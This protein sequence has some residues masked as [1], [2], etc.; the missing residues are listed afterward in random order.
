MTNSSETDLNDSSADNIKHNQS[1]NSQKDKIRINQFTCCEWQ[2]STCKSS[3][4]GQKL[5]CSA[6][7]NP[8][9]VYIVV[10][11]NSHHENLSLNRGRNRMP[12]N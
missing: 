7:I 12:L 1:S 6:D 10:T 4:K 3:I 8:L 9:Q 2:V 5:Q 11:L